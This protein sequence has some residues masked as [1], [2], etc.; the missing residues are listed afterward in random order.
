M[1]KSPDAYDRGREIFTKRHQSSV[2]T[3]EDCIKDKVNEEKY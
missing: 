1:L 2:P 3:S